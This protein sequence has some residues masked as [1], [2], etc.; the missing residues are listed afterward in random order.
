MYFRKQV[1]P[2]NP[3]K[4]Q[5]QE[6]V[7]KNLHNLFEAR[8]R[9]LN[10]FDTKILPIK[11]EGTGFSDKV[12][13]HS[14]L[15]ILTPKQMVQRLPIALAQVKAGNTSENLLNKIRQI[16]HFLYQA[17]EITEKVYNNIMNSMKV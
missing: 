2:K 5:Q 16:I 14:N 13:D 12:S 17:K 15:K 4:K 10:T 7:L 6:D 11:F 8:E 9:V 3:E 1:K